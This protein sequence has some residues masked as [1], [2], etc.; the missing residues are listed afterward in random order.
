[1]NQ[2]N[3]KIARERRM[4]KVRR[5]KT[6]GQRP[7]SPGTGITVTRGILTTGE[8]I[9][10]ANQAGLAQTNYVHPYVCA[11]SRKPYNGNSDRMKRGQ[12]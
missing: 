11:V 2:G 7:A 5:G 3:S 10:V 8:A 1:M 6:I 12:P 9:Y 4:T